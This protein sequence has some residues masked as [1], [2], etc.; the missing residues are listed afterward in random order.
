[1]P[2]GYHRAVRSPS[3]HRRSP[4]WL[5][6]QH[7]AWAILALPF[8]T[9]VILRA[10]HLFLEWYLLP[11][12]GLW[13][14]G[15]LAFNAASLWLK[16][17][18][19]RR[20]EYLPPLLTYASVALAFGALTAWLAG[21]G[22]WGWAPPYALLLAGALW[23]AGR[24]RERVL[25]GGLLTTSAAGLITLVARFTSPLDLVASWGSPTVNES[26]A[27]AGL[28]FG[29]LFGTVL[30]VKTM[31]RERGELAWLNA[32]IGWHA[33]WTLIAAALATAGVTGRWWP[34]FFLATTVRSWWLPRRGA[35]RPV[36][37]KTVGFIEIGFSLALLLVVALG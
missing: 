10:R 19:G 4:G 5:P 6:V 30:Y 1:M 15:Y 29:Y 37:A 13:L 23:L 34:V 33:G 27:V 2:P 36:P 26:V 17:A 35:D 31:I 7:G 22:I 3:R 20:P 21:P 24:R 16:A 12:F 11:L 8:I 28:V 32:S 25:L 14:S 18:P 9:G